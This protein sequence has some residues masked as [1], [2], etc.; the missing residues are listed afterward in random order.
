MNHLGSLTS[1]VRQHADWLEPHGSRV[2]NL[3]AITG[4]HL[5]LEPRRLQ[6]LDTAARFHDVGKI[7]VRSDIVNKPGPLSA[8]EWKEMH[9]HPVDGFWLLHRLVPN[10]V[11]EA[12][13]C[14]HERYDGTGYPFGMTG[15]TIPL[16]SRI[17]F[18]VDAFDA[19]TNDRPYHRA[20]GLDEARSEL[21]R[22]AGTQFDPE[23]IETVID[24]LD[25][26]RLLTSAS[27]ETQ[28][29][30]SVAAR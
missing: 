11:A 29:H 16:L 14:H 18:V 2:A 19:M 20:V 22:G 12:V 17:L 3:A 21:L 30:R 23:V 24:L 4:M 25:Q 6:R 26:G 8:A 10:E 1:L 7:R 13:L 28:S 27:S 15:T 5:R 9:R